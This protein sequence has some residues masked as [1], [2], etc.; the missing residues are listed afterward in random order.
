MIFHSHVSRIGEDGSA[1]AGTRR[2]DARRMGSTR[3][4]FLRRKGKEKVN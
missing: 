1:H 3:G 4:L 2:R